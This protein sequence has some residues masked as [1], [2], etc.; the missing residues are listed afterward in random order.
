MF[1]LRK[2]QQDA[3]NQIQGILQKFKL[4]ILNG[5]VRTGKTLTALDV[6]QHYENVLFV[7]KKK[8]IS[9]IEDDYAMAG[10][11]FSWTIINFESLHKVEGIF[12]LVIVDESH[13]ISAYPKPSKRA[14]DLKRFCSN[15]VIIMTGTLIPESNSQIFH[16]LWI[17]KYSPFNRF[18]NFY[19]WFKSYGVPEVIYTSYG[20]STSYKNSKWNEI[21]PLIDPI[22]V[23]VTQKDA[24]FKCEITD[25]FHKVEMKSFTRTMI[26]KLVKDRV[27]IGK[28]EEIVADTPAKLQ[29]KVHQMS[30]GT[31]KFESG[32]RMVF[33][34]SK[35]KYIAEQF[36]GKKKAIFYKFTAELEAI[37]SVLDI[38]QDIAEFNSTDKDIALQ[39]VSG[40]EGTNL[41]S[42]DCLIMYNI[43]FSAISYWQARDRMTV[44]DRKENHVHWLFSDCGI[45]SKVFKAVTDKK[46]YNLKLFRKDYSIK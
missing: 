3:S 16:Q 46:D 11:S 21:Q 9:S 12:D 44:I 30:S 45:C 18:K 23:I 7:T 10:H 6:A 39:I 22:R 13:S 40:R 41:S 29:Q 42:A 26:K 28:T 8:A 35:A 27:V 36:K 38:T 15:D 37:K 31:I 17:S 20:Q 1:E 33:D 5:E 32:E 25:H 24:G 14:K 34:D 4:C 43:D 2:Y 19:A